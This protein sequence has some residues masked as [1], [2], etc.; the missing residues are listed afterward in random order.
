VDFLVFSLYDVT[1]QRRAEEELRASEEK[2][3]HFFEEDLAGH[4]ISAPDGRLRA[5]NPAFARTF[6]FS[7]VEEAM[8]ENMSSL[9][10]R[11]A[12]REKFIDRLRAE[13]RVDRC[14]KEL[15]RKDGR[16]VHVVE[17]VIGSFG[18]GGELVEFRGFL[19]DETER[20]VAERELRQAQKMEAVGRLAGGVAHDFNNVLTVILG[21][22]ELLQPNLS[23][24]DARLAQLD[25][26]RK[27]AERAAGLTRQ[28]LAFSRKQ[29]LQPTVLDLNAVVKDMEKM[30]ERLIGEDIR[31]ETRLA[32]GLGPVLADRGQIEQVI[33]NLAVNARDAMPRGGTLLLETA[34]GANRDRTGF[35]QPASPDSCAMLAVSDTGCGMN[36]TTMAHLFEPFFTTKE[37][38]KGTGLGL[39]TVFGIVKQSGGHIKVESEPDRGSTFR[40]F[41]PYAAKEKPLAGAGPAVAA[42]LPKGSETI[43]LT[44]D[45]AAL[46]RMAREMLVRA[47]YAVIEASSAEEAL[48][49]AAAHPGSIDLLLT[50]VVMPGESGPELARRLGEARPGIAVLYMSGYTHEAVGLN[51]VLPP[52]IHFIQKPFT[53]SSLLLKIHEVLAKSE[54][55]VG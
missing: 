54:Q 49:Q 33:M 12:D 29:V 3:R 13:G 10:P 46:R 8:A 2:Y 55:L 14:E 30:L 32:S 26:I 15:Q 35:E 31:V 21:Y 19:I 37:K 53:R 22:L 41:L 9:Y 48:A 50:D 6:G 36:A 7:S 27:A 40:I 4:F 52:G 38:G 17:N 43:L 28:L 47:G 16:P 39:A 11:A 34:D 45:E 51:G 23:A 25:E 5:C 20:R 18:D 44:E 24:K 42:P 1:E